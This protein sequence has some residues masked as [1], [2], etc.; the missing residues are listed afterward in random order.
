VTLPLARR[1]FDE[2]WPLSL[3]AEAIFVRHATGADRPALEAAGVTALAAGAMYRLCSV[4][5]ALGG[6]G[7]AASIAFLC[8]VCH[9]VPYSYARTHALE[10]LRPHADVDRVRAL[11]TDALWDCEA[12]AYAVACEVV[13]PTATDVRARLAELATD[14]RED[15]DI[16]EDARRRLAGEPLDGD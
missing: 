6:I 13:D 2:P 1:W 9:H 5:D 7:D 4:V 16:R 14:P 10:A 11:L 8:D 12:G 15:A 3:A